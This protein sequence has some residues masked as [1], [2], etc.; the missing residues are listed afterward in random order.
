[1]HAPCVVG[2]EDS[3]VQDLVL[4][5]GRDECGQALDELEGGQVQ[6]GGA[7]GPGGLQVED[8]GAVVLLLAVGTIAVAC[9][10]NHTTDVMSRM[11]PLPR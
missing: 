10:A 9:A 11:S 4:A 1:M 2:G 8:E 7:V 6:R 3:V 5:A